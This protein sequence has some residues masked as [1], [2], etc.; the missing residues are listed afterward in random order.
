MVRPRDGAGSRA[1]GVAGRLIRTLDAVL[2]ALMPVLGHYDGRDIRQD[3]VG[4]AIWHAWGALTAL[5]LRS[6]KS[7]HFRSQLVWL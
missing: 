1:G 3:V 2:G 7:F 6:G 5:W 4:G